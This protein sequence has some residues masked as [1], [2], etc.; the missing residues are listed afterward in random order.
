MRFACLESRPRSKTVRPAAASAVSGNLQ[1][2]ERPPVEQDLCREMK[3]EDH[4]RP[5]F[6]SL[7]ASDLRGT[8][9]GSGLVVSGQWSVVS[10]RWSEIRS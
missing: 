1:S 3:T 2:R 10:G 5:V 8:M 9:V 4:K 6:N 7:A